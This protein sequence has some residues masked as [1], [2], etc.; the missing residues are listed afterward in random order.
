M[1]TMYQ[2]GRAIIDHENFAPV[3]G[4]LTSKGRVDDNLD[5]DGESF[6]TR[7]MSYMSAPF[8]I[9]MDDPATKGGLLKLARTALDDPSFSIHKHGNAVSETWVGLGFTSGPFMADTEEMVLYKA[10]RNEGE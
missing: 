2:T 7:M 6:F 5:V 10:I 3:P 8:Y 4:M 1:N 9:I